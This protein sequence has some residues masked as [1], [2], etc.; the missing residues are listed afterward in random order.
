MVDYG[1][2]RLKF[3]LCRC[4][5]DRFYPGVFVFCGCM[6]CTRGVFS[7]VQMF[8]SHLRRVRFGECSMDSFTFPFVRFN[9]VFG[10]CFVDSWYFR[11]A[12]FSQPAIC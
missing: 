2:V 1:V 11:C 7:R 8:F 6:V 9:E 10:H 12:F 3:T 4:L 5:F